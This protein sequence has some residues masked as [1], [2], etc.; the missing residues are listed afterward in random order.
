MTTEMDLESLEVLT[1]DDCL[2]LLARAAIGRVGFVVAGRPIV[3]PVN[4]L[5][6]PD[7]T[8]VFR[9]HDRSI[10]TA[11]A[12]HSATF[13]V[14]GY[15]EAHRLGWSVC[16]HGEGREI[17][18][19]DDAVARRLRDLDVDT[20]APGRRDRWFAIAADQITG[21]RL[22]LT[23]SPASFGWLPGIVS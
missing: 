10:L 8:I 14:D 5:A 17:T 12:R 20:W 6:D 23:A 18:D 21:R 3:L 11:V 2:M 13:E 19:S 16:V 4:Y 7:S 1:T 9:T 15:D 22:P